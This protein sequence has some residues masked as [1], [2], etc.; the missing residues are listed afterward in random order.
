M[1]KPRVKRKC[2]RCRECQCSC[3]SREE[4]YLGRI[5]LEVY[6]YPDGTH[7]LVPTSL[8][9]DD[10]P[11]SMHRRDKLMLGMLA[12]QVIQYAQKQMAS[13]DMLLVSKQDME[14]IKAEAKRNAE[15]AAKADVD[16]YQQPLPFKDKPNG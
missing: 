15:A 3:H 2:C 1:A 13:I 9:D 14:V 8:R 10:I 5:V 12:A 6:T 4:G 16:K 7:K 11:E